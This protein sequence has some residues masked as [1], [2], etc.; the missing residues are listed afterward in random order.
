MRLAANAVGVDLRHGVLGIR[1]PGFGGTL[2]VGHGLG[3]AGVAWILLHQ[4]LGEVELG[5]LVAGLGRR[6]HQRVGF[7]LVL[8]DVF[9]VEQHQRVLELRLGNAL[10]GRQRIPFRGFRLVE[11]HAEPA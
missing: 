6:L 9:A 8:L 3:E 1:Q 4:H 7:L 5:Q 2:V 10:F 11:R